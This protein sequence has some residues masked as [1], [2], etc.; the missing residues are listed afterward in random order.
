MSFDYHQ[1]DVYFVSFHW[2]DSLD[3]CQLPQVRLLIGI[4]HIHL[5]EF[6][7]VFPREQVLVVKLEEYSKDPASAMDNIFRF[8]D[9]SKFLYSILFV[10]VP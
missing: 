3:L 4:Y 6:F 9:L 7:R 1:S 2:R 5:K 8:L 10:R